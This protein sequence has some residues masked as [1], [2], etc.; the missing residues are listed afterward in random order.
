MERNYNYRHLAK[1]VVEAETPLAISTGYANILTDSPVVTDINGLPYIPAT[2]LAGVLR[3]ALGIKENDKTT[4]F[5]HHDVDGGEGSKLILTD[6]IMLGKN[7]KAIDGLQT[8]NWDD[9]FYALY[10]ALPIRQHVCINHKGTAKN[11]GKFD[12]QIV[13]KGTRFVFELELVASDASTEPLSSILVQLFSASFRIGG[14]TR[15][16]YGKL[17]VVSCWTAHLNLAD[18]EN[19]DEQGQTDLDSYLSKSAN[20]SVDWSRYTAYNTNDILKKSCANTGWTSYNLILTP[21]DFLFFGA[22]FGDEDADNVFV[23]E[24]AIEW[25]EV[26][27]QTIIYDNLLIPASSVK[28][29]IAHRTAYHYNRLIGHWVGTH[30]SDVDN[31]AVETFFGKVGKKGDDNKRGNVLI[32]DVITLV[33]SDK[34]GVACEKVFHHVKIDYF[35]GGAMNGAL[36]QEKAVYAKDASNAITLQILVKDDLKR[37]E[38]VTDAFEQSLQDICEGLLPLGGATNRGYGIF[39][40]KLVKNG[41]IIYLKDNTTNEN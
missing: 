40:G 18:T 2:S 20:L 5:G 35:T 11:S 38:L 10:K 19:K 31:H 36:F 21:L 13:Y 28:G 32:G 14:G 29:A 26:G 27:Y 9:P 4:Y 12:N 30:T 22:G 23:T 8:I 1:I 33:P 34:N 39:T 41:M 16:G 37:D 3:H 7:G 15:K 24:S 6:A 17:K 25:G